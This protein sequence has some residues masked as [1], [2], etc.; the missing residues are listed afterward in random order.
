MKEFGFWEYTCPGSGKVSKYKLEDWE[1]LLDDMTS[2]GMNSLALN[3][4]WFTTGYKSSLEWLDQDNAATAV[5][6]GNDI[7]HKVMK[8]AHTRKIKVWLV[9]I[10]SFF[11][12][13]EFGIIPPSG[14]TEGVFNYDP[15]QPGVLEKVNRMFEEIAELFGS[16]ADGIIVEMENSDFDWPHRIP[17]YNNWAEE[18]KRPCYEKIKLQHMDPRSYQKHDWRDFITWRRCLALKEVE[19]TVRNRGFTGP[20]SMICEARNEYGSYAQALNLHK[21]KEMMPCWKAVSYGYNRDINRWS[22]VDFCI[23][24]PKK[25]GLEIYY[26]GRGVMTYRSCPQK[27]SISLET[28]WQIDID[29]VKKF[30]P[31]GFW[32][33]GA[34]SDEDPNSHCETSKLKNIGFENGIAARKALIKSAKTLREVLST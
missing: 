14:R 22:G 15:D 24:Q 13:R 3:I 20:L 16:S 21:Y 2:G 19:K 25:A 6:S 10:G 30:Q 17:L 33:F 12:I 32:F 31:E 29:D 7:L 11:Q 18:N 4:K 23:E 1:A 9:V 5:A 28:H 8:M 27:L 34:D 26:L